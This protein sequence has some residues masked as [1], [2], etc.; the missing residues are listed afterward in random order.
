MQDVL[1]GAGGGAGGAVS[2]PRGRRTVLGPGL[3]LVVSFAVA[4]PLSVILAAVGGT[5]DPAVLQTVSL[6]LLGAGA[7]AVGALARPRAS[8]VVGLV[9]WPFFDG[10]VVHRSGVLGWDGVHDTVR[11]AVLVG[12][13]LLGS[14]LGALAPH[15]RSLPGRLRAALDGTLFRRASL[16]PFQ[17]VPPPRGHSWYWN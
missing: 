4:A 9:F 8:L 15:A 1:L 12:A 3:L 13:G 14:L 5:R 11:L 7:C 10:F 17:P 16:E 2:A 6:A